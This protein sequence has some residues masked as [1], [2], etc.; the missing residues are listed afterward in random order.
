MS[1]MSSFQN[2]PRCGLAIRVRAEHIAPQHCPRCIAR[3]QAAVPMY[4][5]RHPAR[6][7]AA[8]RQADSAA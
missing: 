6:L 3:D 5:T 1:S 4:N 8:E 7:E 2:C